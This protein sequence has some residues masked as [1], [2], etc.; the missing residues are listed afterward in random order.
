MCRARPGSG[1]TTGVMRVAYAGRNG[2][3]YTSIGRII[4]ER[5][6]HPAAGDEPRAAD[7]VA[8][9]QS[10]RGPRRSSGRTAPTSSSASPT[11]SI[12]PR[13]RW[14]APASRSPRAAVLRSI[15]PCGA[16]GCRSGSME[17]CRF[18]RR[19]R[20]AAPPHDRQDTGTAI[21]GPARGD[22]FFGSGAEPAPAPV[23]SAILPASS[24]FCRSRGGGGIKGGQSAGGVAMSGD[25]ARHG[26]RAAALG[27]RGA[28]R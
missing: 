8:E 22:F 20:A 19:S 11:S 27:A 14:A 12:R 6:P 13:D 3:P 28:R 7:G 16:T 18:R 9:G 1:L 10:G 2:Q 26:G 4:V 23:C 24:Y 15:T 5:G 21:V 25:R 17:S